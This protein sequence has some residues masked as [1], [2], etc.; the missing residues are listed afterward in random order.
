M[1][2]RYL[3]RAALLALLALALAL[4][5]GA[6]VRAQSSAD[7][8]ALY[9]PA[10]LPDFWGDMEAWA[11]APRYT[12]DLMLAVNAE[13][14]VIGGQA[15]V[16]Y[17]NRAPSATLET[18]VFRLYPNLDSF[19]GEMTV[20]RVTVAGQ[21]V[22]PQLDATRSVLTLPLPRPLGYGESVD[23]ALS[24]RVRVVAGR[25]RL[26]A[27]FS[28]LDEV[29]A[30]PNAYP[31]LSV[32]EA[33]AGWWEEVAHPQGDAVFSE[34]G[35]Y[36]V[37]LTVPADWQVAA[38]G[39]TLTERDNG[40]GTRTLHIAAPLMREFAW[41]ASPRYAT[42]SAEQDGVTVRC[43]YDPA[44]PQAE[45]NAEMA[46]RVTRE[47]VRTYNRAFGRYPF[48]ELD[49]VQTPNRAA[50]IE[51]P[52][53][54]VVASPVWDAGDDFF[55]FVLA[56]ETAHQWWYSLVGNDPVRTPWMD[57]AL[58]QFS[59]ALYIRAQE[60]EAAYQ[61]AL[62]SYRREYTRYIEQYP[63]QVIGL[64]VSAYPQDA[65]FFMVYQKGPLF[66]AALADE[67]G[68]EAL[69]GALRD[70]FAAYRYR[71]AY[72]E[73]ILSEFERSLD[74]GVDALFADWVGV[75]PVG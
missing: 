16:R 25:E 65:Y 52:G 35:F 53:V 28:Y 6:G 48:A 33:G 56:H 12:L 10:L 72:P 44:R 46:L 70:Y 67:Y 69:F 64:P 7:W 73:D 55:A 29:L 58:A 75:V 9:R 23:V 24:F 68:L 62:E 47:A 11:D 63:D 57:E 21:A 1:P 22:T 17:T 61:A 20:G 36:D 60:G 71:I 59:V 13:E 4:S 18:L 31:L 37:R 45:T 34:T 49:V 43:H 40:D 15:T 8:T 39:T 26:Y 51:Y 66:Y 54:F 5:A 19:G 32:Y 3:H 41:F 74:Y 50:G 30:L 42:L 38:S 27:Q 14:A 2:R